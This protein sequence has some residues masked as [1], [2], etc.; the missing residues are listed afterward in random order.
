MGLFA[1]DRTIQL[2]K[3]QLVELSES[4]AR[5]ETANKR[6]GLEWEELYDKVR[7]QMSRMARRAAVDTADIVELPEGVELPTGVVGTDAISQKILA[8]RSGQ[9]QAE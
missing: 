1:T 4:V 7:H 5:L 9:R 8:R 3:N 6:L 2:L